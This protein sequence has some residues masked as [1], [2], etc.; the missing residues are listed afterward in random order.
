[1]TRGL[2]D[3]ASA[4]MVAGVPGLALLP[5]VVAVRPSHAGGL[6]GAGA[7]GLPHHS[8]KRHMWI[9]LQV[10]GGLGRSNL[11][12]RCVTF[13]EGKR[14]RERERSRV[15]TLDSDWCFGVFRAR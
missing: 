12:V 8:S 9:P 6:R 11:R 10:Y 13:S 7:S 5:Q 2:A 14:E 3:G 15:L 1:M 4:G